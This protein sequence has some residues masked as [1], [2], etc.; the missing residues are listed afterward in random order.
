MTERKKDIFVRGLVRMYVQ[1]R[2]ISTLL[3]K[4]YATPEILGAKIRG[5]ITGKKIAHSYGKENRENGDFHGGHHLFAS[6]I[7]HLSKDVEKCYLHHPETE[8]NGEDFVYVLKVSK[9]VISFTIDRAGRD[10]QQ[11]STEIF[12]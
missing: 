9:A 1:D 7:G 10:P 5:F 2:K 4:G 12:D 8:Y 11:I 6:L 3:L